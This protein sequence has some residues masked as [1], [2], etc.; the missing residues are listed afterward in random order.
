MKTI[1]TLSAK[2]M[3]ERL[4]ALDEK[5]AV[6]AQRRKDHTTI[7]FISNDTVRVTPQQKYDETITVNTE[8]FFDILDLAIL[9]CYKCTQG[10]CVKDCKWREH[11]HTLSIEPLRIEVKDGECE[12][13]TNKVGEAYAVTPQYKRVDIP[14][15]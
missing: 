3:W 1:S 9:S 5:Q 10:D 6:S 12:Y 7:R 14:N 15:N 13:S 4:Q 11:F 8:T 2:I